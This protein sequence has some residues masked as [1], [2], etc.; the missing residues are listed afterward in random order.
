MIRRKCELKK[1]KFADTTLMLLFTIYITHRFFIVQ[2]VYTPSSKALTQILTILLVP[3]NGIL[4][5]RA[6]TFKSYTIKI[7]AFTF[8]LGK[9]LRKLQR[10]LTF[11][12]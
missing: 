12:E 3:E 11:S 10:K 7:S 5:Y 2:F 4:A 1:V 6:T 8:Y 9:N